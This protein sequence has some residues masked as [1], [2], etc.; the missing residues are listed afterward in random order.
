M[1]LAGLAPEKWHYF[2]TVAGCETFLREFRYLLIPALFVRIWGPERRTV[3]KHPAMLLVA[4]LIAVLVVSVS[5]FPA[6][7]APKPAAIT[8]DMAPP[9]SVQS[10]NVH[11]LVGV[12]FHAVHATF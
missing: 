12:S 4:M 6:R 1:L 9:Q 2:G 3:M 5:A 11:A 10:A 7:T 8:W